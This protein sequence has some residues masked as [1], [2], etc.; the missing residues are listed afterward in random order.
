[1]PKILVIVPFALDAEGV[2][3]REKQQ[4]YVQLDRRYGAD[5]SAG[6]GGSDILHEPA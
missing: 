2:A 5:L 4:K 1:M 3:N 6:Y